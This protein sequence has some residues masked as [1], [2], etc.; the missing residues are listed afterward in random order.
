MLW[1]MSTRK[2]LPDLASDNRRISFSHLSPHRSPIYCY[3]WMLSQLALLRLHGLDFTIGLDNSAIARELLKHKI[4]EYEA[5]NFLA[6]LQ[7]KKRL[8]SDP[9]QNYL[10]IRFPIL[11]L[12]CKAYATGKPIFE[13]QNQAVVSGSCMVNL[14][15][16]LNALLDRSLPKSE[17][18]VVP[19][20]FSICTEGPIMELWVHTSK[21]EKGICLHFMHLLG[22]CHGS[23]KNE[24]EVFLLRLE[25]VMT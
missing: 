7:R 12:E 16:R 10:N 2:L 6:V 8:I 20:V 24:L 17:S 13:A 5:D 25:H 21:Q 4:S 15:L 19:P 3:H 23:L 14:F 9:T 11:V 22:T 1:T 18:M